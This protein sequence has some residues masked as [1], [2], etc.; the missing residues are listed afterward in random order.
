MYWMLE[1][2]LREAP[3]SL[4]NKMEELK[5]IKSLVDSGQVRIAGFNNNT[6]QMLYTNLVKELEQENKE[7]STI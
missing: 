1:K 5:E 2:M 7:R 6:Y 4:S 3:M